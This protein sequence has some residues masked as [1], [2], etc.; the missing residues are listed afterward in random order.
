MPVG[1]PLGRS[2]NL[3]MSSPTTG[4]NNLPGGLSISGGAP[5]APVKDNEDDGD[6]DEVSHGGRQA[7]A[8]EKRRRR[9]SSTTGK[10][11]ATSPHSSNSSIPPAPLSISP[12]SGQPQQSQPTQISLGASPTS[13]QQQHQQVPPSPQ[14]GS[15]GNYGQGHHPSHH[16]GDASMYGGHMMPPPPPAPYSYPGPGASGPGQG[17]TGLAQAAQQHSHWA[18][19][20]PQVGQAGHYGRR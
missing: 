8:G 19:P 5:G 10:G 3:S 13:P 12:G 11:G 18:G 4:A 17:M 15:G 16:Q 14:Y 6:D 9:A 2:S 1:T 20:P 7:T